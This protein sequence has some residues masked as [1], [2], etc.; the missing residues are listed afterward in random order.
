MVNAFGESV[1]SGSVDLQLVKKVIVTKGQYK[2]YV[3][4]INQSYVLGFPPY[5]HHT[6]GYGTFVTP[7]RVYN[8]RSMYW[9]MLPRWM[10]QVD[11]L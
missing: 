6:N 7:I 8:G 4:E 9:T 1:G 2:D 10:L 11:I 5:R 3:N